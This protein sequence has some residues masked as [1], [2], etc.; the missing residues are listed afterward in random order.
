MRATA[1]YLA[2]LGRDRRPI[3]DFAV[4]TGVGQIKTGS[5]SRSERIAKYNRL[6]RIAEELGPAAQ[7]PGRIQARPA[8]RE[9]QA[10]SRPAVAALSFLTNPARAP[11]PSP[12]AARTPYY[13]S[14]VRDSGPYRSAKRSAFRRV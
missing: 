10:M 3:A 1:R 8:A 12:T 9:R 14:P 5:L 6:L 7:Y 13:V 4:A 2:S 11:K